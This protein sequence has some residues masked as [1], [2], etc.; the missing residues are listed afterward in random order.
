LTESGAARRHASIVS[1]TV[2][3]SSRAPSALA[4]EVA[5]HVGDVVVAQ[6]ARG[7]QQQ[8]GQ[9]AGR[10]QAELAPDRGLEVVRQR[11]REVRAR[12]QLRERASVVV[13]LHGHPSG[14]ALHDAIGRRA[15]GGAVDHH[16]DEPRRIDVRREALAVL[17]AV[18]E[19][20][21]AR[22]RP[23]ERRE[24]R[25]G[26]GRVVRLRRDERPVDGRRLRR[27]GVDACVDDDRT[28]RSL[29][30]ERRER[31]ACAQRQLRPSG[32]RQPAGEHS[33]DGSR[34]D[35]RDGCHAREA[36]TA[37]RCGRRRSN[38]PSFRCVQG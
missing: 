9:H 27:V 4:H 30:R 14:A 35:D 38:R 24:P 3:S 29:D 10:V 22:G 16:R 28:R 18:L 33:A 20:R 6:D 25:G 19:D 34:P 31:A 13:R 1:S 2:A 36:S 15:L 11:D 12:E 8:R 17:D 37:P 26:A 7:L 21:D 5:R 23:D 32:L